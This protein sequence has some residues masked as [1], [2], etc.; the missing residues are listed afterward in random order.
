[1]GP[2]E[3]EVE[4]IAAAKAALEV[5]TGMGTATPGGVV[6][7]ASEKTMASR[8]TRP[9]ST[10]GIEAPCGAPGKQKKIQDINIE[11]LKI[12]EIE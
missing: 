7:F 6:V 9:P 4:A 11:S 8:S 1:M 5:E 10:A 12:K 2:I 3:P